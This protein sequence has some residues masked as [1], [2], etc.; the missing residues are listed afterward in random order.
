MQDE[1][2]DV[3]TLA[4]YQ[5][6][7]AHPGEADMH[8]L[9]EMLARAKKPL[10]ILGGAGWSKKGCDDFLAF[11]TAFDLPV[12]CSY[13]AQD[14]IDNR[15][16]HYVGDVAVGLNPAL[17]KRIAESDLLIAIG[18]RLGEWSTVN[19]TLIDIPRPKQ[20]FVHIYPGA[21]ELGRVYQA[22]LLINAG[23]P[24]ICCCRAQAAAAQA[25]MEQLDPGRAR[26]PRSLAKAGEG[27][28]QG[29]HERNRQLAQQTRAG[30]YHHHQWRG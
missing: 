13:R 19:Y 8:K 27:A 9:R 6:V 24:G 28:R 20:P 2:A 26:R 10:A 23:M 1:L 29:Q 14:M 16:A 21:E 11:A 25:F 3:K 12:A 5:R 18:S 30:G 17:A 15:D 7:A 22:D 4:P